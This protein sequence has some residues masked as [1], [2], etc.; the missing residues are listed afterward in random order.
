MFVL[1]NTYGSGEQAGNLLAQQQTSTTAATVNGPFVLYLR[2][3]QFSSGIAPTGFYSNLMQGS[4]DGAGNM[5]I[6]QNYSDNNG[7]YSTSKSISGLSALAFDSA[8]PGRATFTSASGITYL[9]LFNSNSAVE[10]SVATNGSLDSGWLQPQ[11]QSTFT[12]AA[13]AGNY[14]VGE[15]PLLDIETQ[16]N[17][18]LYK[19]QKPL[20]RSRHAPTL[21]RAVGIGLSCGG[22]PMSARH[23]VVSV[24]TLRSATAFCIAAFGMV[25]FE[26]TWPR[27]CPR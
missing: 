6:H 20:T 1:D 3:A 14:L 9:Y 4:A 11:S 18:S 5:T 17:P 22:S 16:T 7:V 2:G 12:N 26:N 19:E 25:A 10:M 27:S 8:H 13:L 24:S 15:M 23:G 21:R